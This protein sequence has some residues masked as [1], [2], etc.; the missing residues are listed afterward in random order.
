MAVAPTGWQQTLAR[1][2]GIAR[3]HRAVARVYGSL[4]FQAIT[5]LSYLTESSDLDLLVEVPPETDLAALAAALAM[6]ANA[7]PMPVDGELIGPSGAAIK[8]RELLTTDGLLLVRTSDGLSLGGP[9][10]LFSIE[11]TA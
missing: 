11:A 5:G 2:A 7:G 3:H 4:A 1:L 8:W 10:R 6:V 9:D